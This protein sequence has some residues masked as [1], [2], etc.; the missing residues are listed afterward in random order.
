MNSCAPASVAAA[1][2]PAHPLASLASEAAPA[3]STA[4]AAPATAPATERPT[5]FATLVDRIARARSDNAGAQ[6]VSVTLQHADFGRIDLSFAAT[7][8]ASG[9]AGLGVTMHSA[10]PGFA[11]A[12]ANAIERP[13]PAPP[14]GG[15]DTS[16]SGQGAP[17]G[18]MNQGSSDPQRSSPRE[19]QGRAPSAEPPATTPAADDSGIFA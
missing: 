15:G 10:D 8:P 12:A 16:S 18:S 13:A 6:T 14:T 1:Q 2:A 5:D 3:A 9:N 17:G 7:G 4:P 19:A 11:P